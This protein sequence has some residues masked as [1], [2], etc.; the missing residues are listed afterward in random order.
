ML[1]GY[2]DFG[3]P[4]RNLRMQLRSSSGLLR[5]SLTE[6]PRAGERR[7]NFHRT[8][9]R[10]TSKIGNVLRVKLRIHV[11]AS[12]FEKFARRKFT[13]TRGFLCEKK[14]ARTP[15]PAF[16][17]RSEETASGNLL[18]RFMREWPAAFFVTRA[19]RNFPSRRESKGPPPRSA[20]E[21]DSEVVRR[22]L[23]SVRWSCCD[24]K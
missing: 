18:G 12:T 1:R 9:S 5:D 6:D 22:R 19:P 15:A 16:E 10:S 8:A 7:Q 20:R 21:A 24:R 14:F 2:C 13:E 4:E 3:N 11:G 23:G 17:R